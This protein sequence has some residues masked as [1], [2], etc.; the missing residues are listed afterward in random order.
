MGVEMPSG[1]FHGLTYH[2][3]KVDTRNRQFPCDSDGGSDVVA[4]FHKALR[5]KVRKTRAHHTFTLC[6]TVDDNLPTSRSGSHRHTFSYALDK[7]LLRE[8]LYYARHTHYGY[9]T[10][11]SKTGIECPLRQSFSV[12]NGYCHLDVGITKITVNHLARYTIDSRLALGIVETWKSKP[13]YSIA[14]NNDKRTFIWLHPRPNLS[15]IGHIRVISA[16]FDYIGIAI[17]IMYIHHDTLT[18]RKYDRY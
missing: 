12:N 11:Y 18:I 6:T 8:R 17:A 14:S 9:A 10:R 3:Y 15:P 16:F 2:H 5:W 4:I 7:S 13:P 1:K